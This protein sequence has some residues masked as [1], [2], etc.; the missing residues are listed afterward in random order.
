MKTE[1]GLDERDPGCFLRTYSVVMVL[2]KVRGV[3]RPQRCPE[4]PPDPPGGGQGRERGRCPQA[5]LRQLPRNKVPSMAVVLK[6][7]TRTN[8]DAGAVFRDPTGEPFGARPGAGRAFYPPLCAVRP[9]GCPPLVTQ[10]PGGGART[11][12]MQGT[13]H[14]L[15]LEERQ[16]QLKPGAVLL[17]Q[18]VRGAR[19]RPRSTGAAPAAG[20]ARPRCPQPHGSVPAGGGLLPVPPQPL[21]QRHPC[22]PAQDLPARA[23]GLEPLAARGEGASGGP[24]GLGTSSGDKREARQDG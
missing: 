8:V 18:Q 20:A 19:G 16:G 7:L 2:R 11:G 13:V 23:R 24:G 22:Q 1:L 14:R 10:S 12:E 5:A 3:P 6:S 9:R 17:L 4:G 15:L 21:P